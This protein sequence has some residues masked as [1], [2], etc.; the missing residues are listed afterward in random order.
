MYKL[1]FSI[2][3]S[4]FS[5]NGYGV[6]NFF[7]YWTILIQILTEIENS[8]SFSIHLHD[9]NTSFV[10]PKCCYILSLVW[11]R[12]PFSVKRS[13]K[14]WMIKTKCMTAWLLASKC[15]QT[16]KLVANVGNCHTWHQHENCLYMIYLNPYFYALVGMAFQPWSQL[17]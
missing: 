5:I 14:G 12:R 10:S 1:I 11:N 15:S 2:T 8:Q 6:S 16:V 3:N 13:E 17:V 9:L 7:F 4:N